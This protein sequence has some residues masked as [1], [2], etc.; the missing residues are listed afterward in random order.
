MCSSDL[1]RM[2]KFPK[3]R[4]N[5]RDA[6]LNSVMAKDK[7]R[8]HTQPLIANVFLDIPHQDFALAKKVVRQN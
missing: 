6:K 8:V 3:F 7:Y 2:V 1:L 4:S 5:Q